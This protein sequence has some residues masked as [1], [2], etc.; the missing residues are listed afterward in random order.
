M[1]K[2]LFLF[3]LAAA[4]IQVSA[5]YKKA[6]FL[7]K[8]G[9]TYAFSTTMFNLGDGKGSP[10][11]F[12]FS[13]GADNS[14]KRMFSWYDLT[15]IP[16]YKF[17]YQT[18]GYLGSSSTPSTLTIYG[19]SR[20]VWLYGYNVGIY[21]TKHD[22][23][24]KFCAYIP[25]GFNIVIFGQP[26]ISSYDDET[27]VYSQIDKIPQQA[28]FSI[29]IKGGLGFLYNVTEKVGIKLE[30]GYNKIF[31]T[32]ADDTDGGSNRYFMFTSNSYVSLGV[33]LHI[34]DKD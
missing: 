25:L 10:I 5:Q 22:A 4:S 29:G 16:G 3:V 28:A 30:G 24:T 9:R 8:D 1:K 13:G 27:S 18:T 31:N 17:S 32:E 15:F 20:N 11:G 21:L 33:R 6:S 23:A 2:V 12:T 34:V 7:D 14:N 26:K 19:K